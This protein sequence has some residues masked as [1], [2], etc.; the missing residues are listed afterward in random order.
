M[1]RC[2]SPI[3]V[4]LILLGIAPFASAENPKVLIQTSKGSISVELFPDQAPKSVENF[5]DYVD[6]GF[7]DGTVFHR[8]IP[9]FMIQGGGYTRDLVKKPTGAPIANEADNGLKNERGTLAMARTG[10][11]HSA[12]AQ[13]FINLTG[14]AFLDHRSKDASGWGYAVFGKVTDGMEVVDEIAQVPTGAAGPFR[15]DA[16]KET[17][18]IEEITRVGG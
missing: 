3:V 4:L 1:G 11:P 14:N 7:Y 9:G 5:L 2:L 13:F 12:T 17:I 16:P 18:V 8:V 15:K 10:V 6:D